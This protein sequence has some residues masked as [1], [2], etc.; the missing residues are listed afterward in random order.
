MSVSARAKLSTVARSEASG[1]VVKYKISSVA[2]NRDLDVTVIPFFVSKNNPM[3]FNQ[4]VSP[5]N[6]IQHKTGC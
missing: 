6:M 5:N 1:T 2:A 4:L 3:P